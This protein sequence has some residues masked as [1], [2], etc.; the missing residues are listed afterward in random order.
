MKAR[1]FAHGWRARMLER[2]YRFTVGFLW[3][4]LLVLLVGLAVAVSA[5]TATLSMLPSVNN[6]LTDAIEARTGFSARIASI[7]GEMSG[8]QPKLKVK[9][10]A[11]FQPSIQEPVN[12][13]SPAGSQNTVSEALIFQAGQLQITVNP[14]RSLLQRQLILS[15]MKARDVEIPA[16]L[17]NASGSIVIPIDPGTFASEIERL[18]LQNTRVMLLR[19]QGEDEDQLLLE[20]DLDLKRDGS[21]RELQL[22]ARGSGDLTINAAGS[23]VGDPFDLRGFKGKIEGQVT[24]TDIAAMAGFFDLPI[25]GRGD[26]LFWTNAADGVFASIFQADGEVSVETGGNPSNQIALSVLGVAESQG[27]GAWLNVSHI[28]LALDSTRLVL[29]DM[30]LGLF[31]DEWSLVMNDVDVS[32]TIAT[33]IGTNLVPKEIVEIVQPMSPTGRINAVSISGN[34]RQFGVRRAAIDLHNFGLVENAPLPAITNLSATISYENGAGTIQ[35]QSEDFSFSIPTQFKEPLA[36]GSVSAIGDFVVA[37]DRI[38]IEDGRVFSNAGDFI[39][40][41][42]ISASLPLS[43]DSA[44]TPEMTVV[45]GAES[46]PSDRVLKFT[47]Y[48]IDAEAYQWM[49]AS[50]GDG[51]ARDVGFVMRGGL[52]RQD[53]P[54]RS[55]QLSAVADLKT[56]QLM[57]GLPPARDLKGHVAVD[58]ALVTFDLD[59]ASVGKLEVPLAL[60]QVGRVGAVQLLETNADVVA[61]VPNAVDEIAAIPYVPDD[62][63]AALRRLKTDGKMT[64]KFELALPIKGAPRIPEI[65]TRGVVSD[66]KF[67][68]QGLPFTVTELSGD[69]VYQYPQGISGGTL[70]GDFF[71]DKIKLNLDPGTV[72]LGLSSVGFSLS[73]R[74]NLSASTL[75]GLADVS[76]PD[77]L[78][79]GSADVSVAFQAGDGVRLNVM[80]DLVGLESAMPAPFTKGGDVPQP[81]RFDLDMS[82]APEAFISY[83]NVLSAYGLLKPEGWSV[84]AEVGVDSEG[85]LAAASA[86]PVNTLEVNGRLTELD[87]AAWAATIGLL[88]LS[89]TGSDFTTQWDQIAIDRLALGPGRLVG[90]VTSG[91]F[92]GEKL[93]LTLE[94]DFVSGSAQYSREA[95][96]I[97]LQLDTLDLD[98]L[99]E[100]NVDSLS[101]NAGD[102]VAVEATAEGQDQA[103]GANFPPISAAIATL[104]YKGENLGSIGF[105]LDASPD[106]VSLTALSGVIDGVT[107]GEGNEFIWRL[108]EAP[109]TRAS[110][111]LQLGGSEST[112][113]TVNTDSVV[114]FAS[115]SLVSE[116]S[117]TGSPMDLSLTSARGQAKLELNN[118]SFL[119]VS[120]QATGPLRFISIFNLAGL[121]QRANVNQLF[122]PGLTFDKATGDLSLDGQRVV[123]NKFAIRNGG[124]SLDL[125]GNFDIANEVID[126]ELTVTLPLVE[127]IPWVAALAGGLPIAAGAY[128][129]SRVFEDQVTRLSSGVYSVTG[130]VNT[131]EV[132]FIRVFDARRSAEKMGESA[133]DQSSAPASGSDRR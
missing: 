29:E 7:E 110:I 43:T 96:L 103:N 104:T 76:L 132:K 69:I 41:G 57:P 108:G 126:A 40:K 53:Y 26:I 55:I 24:A 130:P 13:A 5:T 124:G 67:S 112:L 98:S 1:V 101:T 21:L 95:H 107:F 109:S 94:S 75:A 88:N 51:A 19:D 25:S 15:E 8:F 38:L 12:G 122:D 59:S 49:Q 17:E 58:N 62:V 36:L 84:L 133:T 32:D 23:G 99:P 86:L 60:V 6:A 65:T 34:Y 42:L 44:A 120:A 31:E 117:W 74:A 54:F 97:S 131:P 73:T 28:D 50:I 56:V 39:A 9:G 47:P 48:R 87:L 113:S 22:S 90:L 77:T 123:I 70:T 33:V 127:N 71:G 11:L 20:V 79:S 105:E 52:R 45:L 61:S 114:N 81:L 91:Q 102:Q 119:P 100:F 66:A 111:N 63:G 16:R 18:T 68:Y 78:I 93:D 121:V 125:G 35:I 92:N 106:A 129:A 3:R 89:N 118:G 85:G 2:A 82:D 14:W 30:H 4:T 83:G 72:D 128:L 80:S 10:L 27:S 116:L 115:G 46:A 64:A 37:E